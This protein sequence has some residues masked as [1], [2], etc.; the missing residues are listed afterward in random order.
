MAS[1]KSAA[2]ANIAGLA[3]SALPLVA[4]LAILALAIVLFWQQQN[5]AR[6]LRSMRQALNER[7][8]REHS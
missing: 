1:N 8:G 3:L 6:E 5:Q 4:F 2:K 7:L